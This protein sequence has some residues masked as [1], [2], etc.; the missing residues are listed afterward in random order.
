M[1]EG[2]DLLAPH[3]NTGLFWTANGTTA[4]Y[5]ALRAAGCRGRYVAVQPNVCP[6]VVASILASSNKPWFV[7]IERDRLG[8]DPAALA[9][10]LPEVGAVVAVH[11]YGTPCR[12]AEIMRATSGAGVPLIEDCAQSEGATVN[13]EPVGKFGDYAVFS[14]GEGKIVAAGGGGVLIE[15][16]AGHAAVVGREI[17][18]LPFKDTEAASRR[19]SEIFKQIYNRYYPAVPTAA[20]GEFTRELAAI[21]PELLSQA[22]PGTEQRCDTARRLL[23]DTVTARRHKHAIYAEVFS[24]VEGIGFTPLIDGAVPWRFNALIDPERRDRV[25]HSLLGEKVPASTW[26]PNIGRFLD[27]DT[28]RTESTPVADWLDERILNLWLDDRTSDWQILRTA[29][30]VCSLAA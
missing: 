25:F 30:T 19:L 15:R 16:E 20:R 29:K 11:S 24:R 28:F 6:N 12:I 23:F 2:G 27:P 4:L 10:V 9:E 7:D 17:A 22:A 18:A 21:T 3:G 14:Y 5:A 1:A 8:L 26:Y 13:G